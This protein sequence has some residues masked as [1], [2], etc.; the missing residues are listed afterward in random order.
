VK[1]L[2]NI[3]LEIAKS[4]GGEEVEVVGT[5]SREIIIEMASQTIPTV[6]VK[7]DKGI[8]VRV[9]CNQGMGFS[10]TMQIDKNKIRDTAIHAVELAK[11][12]SAD[13]NFFE[14]PAPQ[15]FTP[16]EGLFDES[17]ANISVE[18][19]I[20]LVEALIENAVKVNNKISL[21]GRLSTMIKET[22]LL[23]SRGVEFFNKESRV[24]LVVM[25]IIKQNETN[26]GCGYELFLARNLEEINFSNIGEEVVKK[27][28]RMLCSKQLPTKTT[29]LLLSPLAVWGLVQALGRSLNAYTILQNKS[30]LTDKI[31]KQI[32]SEKITLIDDGTIPNGFFS[33]PVDGEGVPKHRFIIIKDGILTTYLHDSNTSKKMK[34]KNNACSVRSSYKS[35][36]T[37]GLSNVEIMPG[38]K[39]FKSLLEE[40]E[41]GIYIDNFPLP[42]PI[43][44]HIS[45]MIDFGI[46]IKKGKLKHSVKNTMIGTN[47]K[48]LLLN[49][50]EIS[51]DRR[52]IGGTLLP[53]LTIKNIQ[54][55]GK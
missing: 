19:L 10:Y 48:D 31:G 1:E 26:V 21:K 47:F 6:E 34:I 38:E 9:Y 49:I 44:G 15:P 36:P 29:S 32:T 18:K 46:E 17:I 22:T 33:S 12:S 16:V 37:I 13:P 24:S 2:T 41:E 54:I 3:A 30:F 50:E 39:N 27:A 52:N 43:T 35:L 55:A 11:C 4:V 51:K 28:V 40:I 25:S 8:G 53:Y 23:N 42:N 45:S 14:I 5:D 20:T 7:E